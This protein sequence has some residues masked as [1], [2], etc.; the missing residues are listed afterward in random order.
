MAITDE[1]LVQILANHKN[2]ILNGINKRLDEMKIEIA[3]TQH[4][5]NNAYEMATK[6]WKRNC[7]P[8]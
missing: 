1:K 6:K 7:F 4:T 8:P 3:N 5:A 2:E